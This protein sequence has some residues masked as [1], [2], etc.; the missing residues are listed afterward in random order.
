MG[1]PPFGVYT[2]RVSCSINVKVRGAGFAG[3]MLGPATVVGLTTGAGEVAETFPLEP[4]ELLEP[5]PA[6]GNTAK[7]TRAGETVRKLRR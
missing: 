3:E 4:A 6:I 5:Q 2:R 1:V 7:A